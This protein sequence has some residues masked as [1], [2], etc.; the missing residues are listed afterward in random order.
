VF[1]SSED[2]NKLL[3]V[4]CFGLAEVILLVFFT[5][6]FFDGFAYL[7]DRYKGSRTSTA[8][9][10]AKFLSMVFFV[11]KIA[12]NIAPELYS[13]VKAKEDIEIS[14]FDYYQNLMSTKP[15]AQV[16]CIFAVLVLGIFWYISVL[17]MLRTAKKEEEFKAALQ[18][19]YKTDYLS[20]PEKQNYIA[21]KYGLYIALAGLIFFLDISIDN[22]KIFP[23][24]VS[25]LLIFASAQ[26]MKK[27]GSF[28]MTI[29]YFPI[30]F[31]LQILVEA[32]GYVFADTD[33]VFLSQITVVSI[34]VNALVAIVKTLT[35]VF[36]L[37]A[38][39]VELRHSYYLLAGDEAPTF[40]LTGIM[41]IA[42]AGIKA[43]QVTLPT[44]VAATTGIYITLLIVWL[45]LCGK[46]IIYMID[47]YGKTVRLL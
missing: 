34:G 40:D 20:Y 2:T 21:L 37:G 10:N 15:I 38:F 45:I 35:A 27:F 25:I 28:Q 19:L 43:L 5:L 14:D 12:L 46:N 30:V 23:W 4:F 22:V 36:Y 13:L 16:L 17:K 1:L 32:Y 6:E 33:A 24:A 47:D 26:K 29:R 11:T 42:L 31:I 44:T 8:V 9:P 18:E 7:A 41:F 3:A 39:L